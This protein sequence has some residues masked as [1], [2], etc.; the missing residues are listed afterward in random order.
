MALSTVQKK[1]CIDLL[2][3]YIKAAISYEKNIAFHLKEGSAVDID[4]EDSIHDFL[5]E[6]GGLFDDEYEQLKAVFREYWEDNDI[7][8][9]FDVSSPDYQCPF[10]FMNANCSRVFSLTHDT[11]E[12]ISYLADCQKEYNDAE[13]AG[14]LTGDE[15]ADGFGDLLASYGLDYFLYGELYEME[16]VEVD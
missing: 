5:N 6:H 12:L 1:Q 2:E 7:E 16:W 13:E 9:S 11:R 3:N 15:A 14:E 4:G 8:V 10:E